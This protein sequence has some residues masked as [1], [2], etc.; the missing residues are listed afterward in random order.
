METYEKNYLEAFT[1]RLFPFL[2]YHTSLPAEAPRKIVQL[3]IQQ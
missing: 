1:R 2:A 3:F